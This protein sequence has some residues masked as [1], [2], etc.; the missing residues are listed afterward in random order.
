M[1]ESTERSALT[2]SPPT[3]R[4]LSDEVLESLREAILGGRLAPGE[5]LRENLLAELI[6]VSRGP[7]RDAL[8]QLEREGLVI[9][10]RNRTAFVARL[11]RQDVDEVY[12]LR[13]ALECLA[14]QYACRNATDADW[15]EMQAVIDAMG[16]YTDHGMTEQEAAE[17]DLR[18]HDVLYQAGKHQRLVGCWSDLRPQI[19]VFLLTRNVANA[20][21]RDVAVRGHQEILDALKDRDENRAVSIIE[22]H[23][24]IGYARVLAFYER[25]MSQPSIKQFASAPV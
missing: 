25:Q 6:G 8:R 14:V 9:M 23:L 7:V 1:S 5:Q 20:D 15:N 22:K 11:S 4:S 10:R 24:Q 21:F 17:L 13:N 3:R 2:L 16:A 18:F 12:S 19:H